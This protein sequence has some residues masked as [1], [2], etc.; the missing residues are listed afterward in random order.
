MKD[1]EEL[2]H[3]LKEERRKG[4]TIVFTN[5]CFDILHPGHLYLLQEAKNRGDILV[6]GINS[7]A[8]LKRLKGEERPIFPQEE[9]AEILASLEMVDYATVFEEDN[10]YNIINEL[11]PR[12]LVK[13]G[14]WK[15]EEVIGR[16]LVESW[17]GEVVIIPYKK[18]YSTSGI[19]DKIKTSNCRR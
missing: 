14:D 11:K 19:L 15:K 1:R 18:G 10:P 2:K 6:V 13:G 9:R 7:D 17:G 4:K 8:S 5:G 16:D 3:I 12:V